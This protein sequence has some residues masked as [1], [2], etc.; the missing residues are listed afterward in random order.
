MARSVVCVLT[1]LI[2]MTFGLGAGIAGIAGVALSQLPM[3]KFR[4]GL[5]H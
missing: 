1:G 4:S 2:T 5:Y 3:L